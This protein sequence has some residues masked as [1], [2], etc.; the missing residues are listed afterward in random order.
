[1]VIIIGF[2]LIGAAIVS[3]WGWL[4]VKVIGQ[5]QKLVELEQ[6]INAQSGILDER[7]T[8]LRSMDRKLDKVSEDTAAIR[9]VLGE[10]PKQTTTERTIR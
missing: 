2:S 8:W 10:L 1:V 6:R 7:L 4:A 9:G 5:G 3:F